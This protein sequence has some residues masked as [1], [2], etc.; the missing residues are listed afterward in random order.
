MTP[1]EHADA[2]LLT[3]SPSSGLA[4]CPRGRTAGFRTSLRM[5]FMLKQVVEKEK[6]RCDRGV[7]P[8]KRRRG[9]NCAAAFRPAR[10][11]DSK[12]NPMPLSGNAAGWPVF[13][14]WRQRAV[15]LKRL[16]VV[17]AANVEVRDRNPVQRVQ[18]PPATFL[19]QAMPR[20]GG[21]TAGRGGK[22]TEHGTNRT[23]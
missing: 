20:C 9:A 14:L 6:Q 19:R 8:A 15:D 1:T 2:A 16:S 12:Q 11:R 7:T 4:S 3:F 23:D 10:T 13:S 5:V 22:G 17:S 18:F 21:A